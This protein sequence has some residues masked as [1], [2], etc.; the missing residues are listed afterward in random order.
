MSTHK[1]I[2]WILASPIEFHSRPRPFPGKCRKS[3]V[4]L[5]NSD[6]ALR[7]ARP[8]ACAF[9]WL[10]RKSPALSFVPKMPLLVMNIPGI[11]SPK[12]TCMSSLGPSPGHLVSWLSFSTS[13]ALSCWHSR[14]REH[15]VTKGCARESSEQHRVCKPQV[16]SD[17][18]PHFLRR[19]A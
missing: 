9:L 1:W 3:P 17:A 14:S 7:A 6:S 11:C 8:W 10:S 5:G 18:N 13:L 16:E 19:N 15:G 12:N 2:Y 4:S